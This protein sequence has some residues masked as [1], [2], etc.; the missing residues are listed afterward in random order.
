MAQYVNNRELLEAIVLSKEKGELSPAAL[1]MLDRMVKEISK[2]FKYKME[3]DRE[4]C[5]AFAMEDVI[6]Y[7]DRFNPEK[8]NNAFAFYTQMIK[9]G[10]AK[11]WRRLYP[12]KSSLKVSISKEYGVYNIAIIPPI[13]CMMTFLL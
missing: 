13:L 11:G 1:K 10:Y 3:E 2:V 6:K 4:D 7:W 12:I 5:M 8:S 9:N